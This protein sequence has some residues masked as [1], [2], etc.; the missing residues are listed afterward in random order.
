MLNRKCTK[1]YQIP[2]TNIQ[3]DEGTMVVIPVLG[4]QRDP[5]FYPQPEKF[6]PDRFSEENK[7][8]RPPSTFIPFGEGPR[9]CI[10]Q[11]IF[12]HLCTFSFNHASLTGLRFGMLQ[13]KVGL[14]TILQNYEITL[15]KKTK[16]PM[17]IEKKVLITTSDSPIWLNVTRLE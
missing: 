14:A 17:E 8:K 2:N 6:D 12:V 15:D 3:L 11:Q 13:T 10:G 16:Q 9:V 5:D 1:A 7:K 4:I